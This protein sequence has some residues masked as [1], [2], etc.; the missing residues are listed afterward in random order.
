[1]LLVAPCVLDCTCVGRSHVMA[2]TPGTRAMVVMSLAG[3]FAAYPPMIGSSRVMLPPALTTARSVERAPVTMMLAVPCTVRS[4]GSTTA[5]GLRGGVL[6]A[7]AVTAHDRAA[8]K[9]ATTAELRRLSVNAISE[10]PS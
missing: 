3:T 9:I 5:A 7:G 6:A 8:A 1:M 4:A 10:H 2:L